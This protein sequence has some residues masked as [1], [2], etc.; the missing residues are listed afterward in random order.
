MSGDLPDGEM[1]VLGTAIGSHGSL[2]EQTVP[3]NTYNTQLREPDV[4]VSNAEL[5]FSAAAR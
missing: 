4:P 3:L 2:H 5:C 1:E